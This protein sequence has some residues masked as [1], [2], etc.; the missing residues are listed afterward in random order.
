MRF[1]EYIKDKILICTDRCMADQ[2][3]GTVHAGKKEP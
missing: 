2:L 1:S 3:Y